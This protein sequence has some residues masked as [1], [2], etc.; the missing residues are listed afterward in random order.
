MIPRD[1]LWSLAE[2]VTQ[3]DD[4]GHLS[5]FT[6]G[7][8][9]MKRID[10]AL[11]VGRVSPTTLCVLRA[12]SSH[13]WTMKVRHYYADSF[14]DIDFHVIAEGFDASLVP[15]LA[16]DRWEHFRKQWWM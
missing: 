6:L 3:R 8:V 2:K 4:A 5:R 12:T 9:M 7:R 11:I 16:L 14:V 15:G 1:E 10:D 13:E